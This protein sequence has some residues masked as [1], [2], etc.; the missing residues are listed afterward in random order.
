MFGLFLFALACSFFFK[1]NAFCF[2]F[3]FLCQVDKPLL[4]VMQARS[5]LKCSEYPPP[6]AMV[7]ELESQE[8][9]TTFQGSLGLTLHLA[10]DLPTSE[11]PIPDRR[12]EQSFVEFSLVPEMMIRIPPPK[13][14]HECLEAAFRR[15]SRRFVI[16]DRKECWDLR[17]VALCFV[18]HGWDDAIGFCLFVSVGNTGW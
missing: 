3:F 16:P 15:N 5:C 4:S 17:V 7:V 9:Q 18:L 1:D 8:K 12:A 6:E 2:S 10:H 11:D 14:V 13:K